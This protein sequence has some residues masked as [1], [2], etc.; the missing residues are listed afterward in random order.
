MHKPPNKSHKKRRLKEKNNST[1][2]TPPGQPWDTQTFSVEKILT[3]ITSKVFWF[4]LR[5][6]LVVSQDGSKLYLVKWKDFP[7]SE[8]TLCDPSLIPQ[9]KIQQFEE[10]TNKLKRALYSYTP[11][12]ESPTENRGDRFSPKHKQGPEE[13]SLVVPVF[14]SL[15]LLE[16]I[17]RGRGGT[18]HTRN[19][20]EEKSAGFLRITNLT[21]RMEWWS[22][23]LGGVDFTVSGQDNRTS[24]ILTCWKH[25]IIKRIHFLSKFFHQK[26]RQNHQLINTN[27]ISLISSEKMRLGK[28]KWNLEFSVEQD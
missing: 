13:W 25:F 4:F 16:W 14:L 17:R 27:K 22:I 12:N 20:P 1:E 15:T 3:S 5:L 10:C 18:L 21:F 23:W 2:Q 6:W 19:N 28:G 26:K 7:T 8:G 9:E 11:E 24:T